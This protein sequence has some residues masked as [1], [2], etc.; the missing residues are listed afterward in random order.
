M[1]S[2]RD[3]VIFIFCLIIIFLILPLLEILVERLQKSIYIEF[4]FDT[5]QQLIEG[6]GL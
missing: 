1:S 5:A 2:E 6:K 4:K 3:L